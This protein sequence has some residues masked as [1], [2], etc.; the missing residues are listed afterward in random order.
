MRLSEAARVEAG[1]VG[2]RRAFDPRGPGVLRREKFREL[3][4]EDRES[5]H[6]EERGEMAGAGVVA[7]KTIGGRERGEEA[8]EVAQRVVEHHHVPTRGGEAGGDLGETFEG[9]QSHRVTGTGVEDDPAGRAGS[10]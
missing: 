7:D 3:R 6:A 2:A 10:S 8:I 1:L 4:A 9:P 5:R